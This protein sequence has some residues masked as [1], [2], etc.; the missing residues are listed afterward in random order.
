MPTLEKP[1]VVTHGNF[2]STSLINRNH[3]AFIGLQNYCPRIGVRFWGPGC[4]ISYRR[5]RNQTR[6]FVVV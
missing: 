3:I 1:L 4:S 2:H 6:V 5:R